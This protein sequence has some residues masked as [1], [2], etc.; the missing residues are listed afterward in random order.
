M[1]CTSIVVAHGDTL[2]IHLLVEPRPRRQSRQGYGEE[3]R[4]R[5][6]LRRAAAETLR[7]RELLLAVEDLFCWYLRQLL[8]TLL[9]QEVYV[10]LNA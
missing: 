6:A 8:A 10:D 3:A 2:R 5:A 7:G 1:V 4:R 9:G